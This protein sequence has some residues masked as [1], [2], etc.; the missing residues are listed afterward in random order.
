MLGSFVWGMAGLF[1]WKAGG[2]R[3]SARKRLAAN[4]LPLR[5]AARAGDPHL[6]RRAFADLMRADPRAAR[7]CAQDKVVS[8]EIAAL[9]AFLFGKQEIPP[10]A[11]NSLCKQIAR[12]LRAKEEAQAAASSLAPLDGLAREERRKFA[13]S[14]WIGLARSLS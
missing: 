9:D 2:R 13:L 5:R 4:L 1:L 11:L 6:F 10:P 8:A 7:L 3:A 14:R 12:A